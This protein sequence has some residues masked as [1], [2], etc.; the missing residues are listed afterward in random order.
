MA[1]TSD[2]WVPDSSALIKIKRIVP[3]ASQ[4][5][6]FRKLEGLVDGG[7]IAIPR[8]VINEMGRIAH[9]DAPGVWAQG[10]RG[11]LIHP[12][13]PDYKHVEAVMAGAGEVVDPNK[14]EED[15]DPYVLA[16]A[17]QLGSDKLAT[18]VTDERVDRLPIKICMTTACNRLHIPVCTTEDFLS[19]LSIPFK[20]PTP[21]EDD[22]TD[23]D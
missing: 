15:A 19:A 14:T 7:A 8:Q 16:L 20:A 22:D 23:E 4:W 3:G 2:I 9:P 12:Q 13:D 21:D 11:R 17:R 6:A 1:L 5:D 10:M 18:V